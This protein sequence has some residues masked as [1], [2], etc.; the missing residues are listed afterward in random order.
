MR[1]ALLAIVLFV[2]PGVA[3][4]D[5]IMPYDGACPPGLELGISGHAEACIPRVCT[6]DAQCGSGAA[7]R[8]LHECW[9]ERE[10]PH[11]RLAGTERRTI[12]V[13]ACDAQR[14]CADADATCRTRRRCEP[15]ESTPAWDPATRR[16]TGV[17]HPAGG[18]SVARSGGAAPLAFLIAGALVLLRRR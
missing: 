15:T 2:M 10:V 17:S 12:V 8:A 5:A 13:G 18:C 14:R 7:C 16:W 11:Q 6:S 4:A 1:S 9:A 3:R